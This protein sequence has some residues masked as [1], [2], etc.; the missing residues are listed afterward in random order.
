MTNR[1]EVCAGLRLR[2]RPSRPRES[3]DWQGGPSPFGRMA[4]PG[5]LPSPL[6]RQPRADRVKFPYEHPS[7]IPSQVGA[8]AARGGS[9][10]YGGGAARKPGTCR[11]GGRSRRSLETGGRGADR[12][13][14]CGR[15]RDGPLG[16]SS[17]SALGAVE[18]KGKDMSEVIFLV[19]EEA[20][21]GYT[22]RALGHSIFTQGESLDE[23]RE[24][25]LDAARC[26]FPDE[27][28][29]PRLIR[30]HMVRDEVLAL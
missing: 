12:C 6:P 17:R 20:E 25:V 24:K 5:P 27:A 28:E 3:G 10:G 2:E 14:R 22:A 21:G 8:R 4:F 23:L 1:G 9:G 7:G 16:R 18:R 26:H 30:L 11:L 29:R 19:E 13:F 15:S